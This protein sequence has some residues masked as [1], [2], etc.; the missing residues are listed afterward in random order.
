MPMF[1][2]VCKLVPS[3]RQNDLQNPINMRSFLGLLSTTN[4]GEQVKCVKKFVHKYKCEK[5]S[6]DVDGFDAFSL[7]T[8]VVG[9]FALP[10]CKLSHQINEE[11]N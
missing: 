4:K 11:N 6:C 1:L 3:S 5:T 8:I 2:N 7:L 10:I 9:N